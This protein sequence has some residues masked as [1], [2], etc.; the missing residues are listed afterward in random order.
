MAVQGEGFNT[1]GRQQILYTG[2]LSYCADIEQK[3]ARMT[4]LEWV[5]IGRPQAGF[6]QCID[7]RL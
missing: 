3:K 6:T 1:R 7:L 4:D 2:E 5:R